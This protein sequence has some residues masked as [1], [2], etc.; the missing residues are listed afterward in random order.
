MKIIN[1]PVNFGSQAS[2][3][4]IGLRKKNVKSDT[5]H[6]NALFSIYKPTY[7]F[8]KFKLFSFVERIFYTI[9]FLL[10][11]DTFLYHAGS[12][13]FT[14]K[15]NLID[16]RLAKFFKKKV[17]PVFHGS[18]LRMPSKEQ[19]RNPF[20]TNTAYNESDSLALKRLSKWSTLTDTVITCD[21]AFLNY[22]LE[23]H[24]K[25][26]YHLPLSIDISQFIPKSINNQIPVVMHAPS[27]IDAKGT[28]WIRD[29]VAQLKNQDCKFEYVEIT[30]K[31]HEDVLE[32]IQKA[33]IVIDQLMLGNYGVFAIEAMALK[34]PVICYLQKE[35][36][37]FLPSDLP[38]I[39]ASPDS[40][41]DNLRKLINLSDSDRKKI[42]KQSRRYVKNYHDCDLVAEKLKKIIDKL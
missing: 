17:I 37:S 29:A 34:K 36:V 42:G 22:G 30:G 12:S 21:V 16:V 8:S 19:I 3:I 18:E 13:L 7:S 14:I 2:I 23:K 25:E 20:Y 31:S 41:I 5:L 35:V 9:F 40:I 1:L 26:I 38:I 39:N 24:F 28:K 10:K 11:Y 15:L 33:D 27:N 32:T 6:S 4:S